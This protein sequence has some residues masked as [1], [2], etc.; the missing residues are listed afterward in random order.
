MPLTSGAPEFAFGGNE[1]Q[2]PFDPSRA[3]GERVQQ[4]GDVAA[5]LEARYQNAIRNPASASF[6]DV[7]QRMKNSSLS[8]LLSPFDRVAQEL[9]GARRPTDVMGVVRSFLA[10]L[11]SIRSATQAISQSA[12]S[13][14]RGVHEATVNEAIDILGAMTGACRAAGITIMP[15]TAR[16]DIRTIGHFIGRA[17]MSSPAESTQEWQRAVEGLRAA[18]RTSVT[19]AEFLDAARGR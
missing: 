10:A 6:A 17:R 8:S 2:Q 18:G 16:T 15:T 1:R 7:A 3:A 19:L 13:M 14:S 11:M 9:T 12:S 5:M 4:L